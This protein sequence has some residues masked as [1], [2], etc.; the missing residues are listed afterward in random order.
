MNIKALP[1][2]GQRLFCCF[3]FVESAVCSTFAERIK[4]TYMGVSPTDCTD[5]HRWCYL[6]EVTNKTLKQITQKYKI[7]QIY[8]GMD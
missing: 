4:H 5:L 1:S 7:T 8:N 2:M 6:Q 3:C